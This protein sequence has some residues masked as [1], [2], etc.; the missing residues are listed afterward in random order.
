MPELTNEVRVSLTGNAGQL[1]LFKSIYPNIYIDYL[2]LHNV[3]KT[4][5]GLKDSNDGTKRQ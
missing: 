4:N 5:K 3:Y 2:K 1:E